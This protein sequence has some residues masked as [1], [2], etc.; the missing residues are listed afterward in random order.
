MKKK[1][2][3]R[4]FELSDCQV[5]IFIPVT[6]EYQI[7]Q[8]TV[9]G[10]YCPLLYLNF[11]SAKARQEAFFKYDIIDANKFITDALELIK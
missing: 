6:E 10:D 11:S 8:T 5:L 3:C 4:L 7:A 1:T 9:I 2:F